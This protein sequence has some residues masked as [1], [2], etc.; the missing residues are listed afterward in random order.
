MDIKNSDKWK[1][2]CLRMAYQASAWSK[3]Q[4]T[5][6]G[7]YITTNDGSPK[8]FG[9]NGLPRN[10]DD[11]VPSRHERPEKYMWFEHAERNSIYQAETSLEGCIM[12]VTHLPCPDCA[13]GIVQKKISHLIV[14]KHNGAG[15]APEKGR[16]YTDDKYRVTR[17]LLDEG[18]VTVELVEADVTLQRIGEE[19]YVIPRSMVVNEKKDENGVDSVNY[20]CDNVLSQPML[21]YFYFEG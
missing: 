1:K 6:V 18:G 13:R 20:K 17:E 21:N 14:D 8:S 3:D 16:M 4:S 5:Q 9:F 10:V 11:D 15:L 7:A 19:L 2:R 12:F